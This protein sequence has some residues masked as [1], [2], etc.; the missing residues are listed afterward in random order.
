MTP[1]VKKPHGMPVCAVLYL[2]R[3]KASRELPELSQEKSEKVFLSN[4]IL[5]QITVLA[6]DLFF[7]TFCNF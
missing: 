5:K 6:V 1:F 4:V 7:Y 2:Y 3:E